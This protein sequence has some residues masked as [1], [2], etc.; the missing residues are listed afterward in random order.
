MTSYLPLT[1]SEYLALSE[2]EYLPLE[3]GVSGTNVGYFDTF[4]II[5]GW[6]YSELVNYRYLSMGNFYIEQERPGTFYIE[7]SRSDTFYIEQ[8]RNNTFYIGTTGE[9]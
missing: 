3:E 9:V 7:Q 8:V 4:S 5:F 6:W 1:E 2:A